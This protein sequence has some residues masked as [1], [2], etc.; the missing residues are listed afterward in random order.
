[1]FWATFLVAGGGA[2]YA[3]K[4]NC[5]FLKSGTQVSDTSVHMDYYTVLLTKAWDGCKVYYNI[6]TAENKLWDKFSL[7]PILRLLTSSQYNY[8]FCD[9]IGDLK[10][11]ISP[12]PTTNVSYYQSMCTVTCLILLVKHDEFCC[13]CN[14]PPALFQYKSHSV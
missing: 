4:H 6:G 2:I 9:L 13:C 11:K 3:V 1:V 5:I 14:A 12:T 8:A 7:L 10:S